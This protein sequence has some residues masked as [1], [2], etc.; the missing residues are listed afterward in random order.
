MGDEVL[1]A[2]TRRGLA[3]IARQSRD[4]RLLDDVGIASWWMSFFVRLDS[5]CR[6]DNRFL[7]M[8]SAN[9]PA[10]RTTFVVVVLT[11]GIRIAIR[12]ASTS[13]SRRTCTTVRTI[14]AFCAALTPMFER[15]QSHRAYGQRL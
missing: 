6:V 9:S 4:S 5:I 15:E 7:R 13:R 11:L 12:T 3:G 2:L 14:T 8:V 10:L 1:G